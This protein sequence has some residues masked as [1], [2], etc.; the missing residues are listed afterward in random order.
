MTPRPERPSSANT[1]DTV[2]LFV[3]AFLGLIASVVISVVL[4]LSGYMSSPGSGCAG[5][6]V[7]L[8]A[9]ALVAGF[10]ALAWYL[11]FR[12]TARSFVAGFARGF[13]AVLALLMLI[14]W[15]CSLGWMGVAA[16]S[17]R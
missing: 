16:L 14:P 12:L 17:C 3:G 13:V 9:L 7:G 4:A 1:G 5:V 2:G 10:L 6:G 8:I 15:P 11:V